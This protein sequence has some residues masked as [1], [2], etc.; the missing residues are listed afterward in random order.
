MV[1]IFINNV[2]LGSTTISLLSVYRFGY[3]DENFPI[4][5]Q[6]KWGGK[7][8][9]GLLHLQLEFVGPSQVA[10]P[11]HQVSQATCLFLENLVEK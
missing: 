11:Q 8:N 9:A 7:D 4:Y 3:V 1:T 10:F 2:F 6:G 5:H